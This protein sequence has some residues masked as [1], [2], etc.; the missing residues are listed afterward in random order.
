MMDRLFLAVVIAGLL[1]LTFAGEIYAQPPQIVHR[2]FT[3]ALN[4]HTDCTGE[5]FSGSL[6]AQNPTC[7]YTVLPLVQDPGVGCSVNQ[8]GAHGGFLVNG[9]GSCKGQFELVFTSFRDQFAAEFPPNLGDEG[10]FDVFENASEVT[11]GTYTS[12]STKETGYGYTLY[13]ELQGIT[14]R[15]T[16]LN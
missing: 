9:T 4:D 7:T 6:T 15:Q 10:D 3:G 12:L 2:T 14:T 5:A 16:I 1:P 11:T 13:M 8:F